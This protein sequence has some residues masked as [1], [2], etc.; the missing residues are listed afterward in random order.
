LNIACLQQGVDFSSE[1]CLALNIWTK[2]LRAGERLKPVLVYIHGGGL[3]SGWASSPYQKPWRFAKCVMTS[4]RHVS[5]R[6]IRA[7]SRHCAE[8]EM[9]LLYQSTIV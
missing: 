9:P 7:N 4:Y 2:P 5:A 6:P 1:D 3:V 8:M